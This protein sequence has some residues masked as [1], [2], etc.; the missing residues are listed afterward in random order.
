MFVRCANV[1]VS[2]AGI[3]D[4]RRMLQ[5]EKEGHEYGNKIAV[6]YWDRFMGVSGPNDPALD[7]ISPIKHIDAVTVPVL[8]IHGKD[9][10]VVDFEQSTVMYNALRK[11]N[12][13]VEMVKLKKEDHWLSRGETRLQMLQSSVEF[14]RKY[15]PPDP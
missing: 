13:N 5:W 8:L 12:K 14:L 11:A 7:P 15:N 3:S 2:V 6:R 4:L 10:T 1:A 9:D